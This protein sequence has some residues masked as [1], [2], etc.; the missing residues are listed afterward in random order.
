[1]KI[2]CVSTKKIE[3]AEDIK[4]CFP[5]CE[6]APNMT[7]EQKDRK[8]QEWLD[9]GGKDNFYFPCPIFTAEITVEGGK[10]DF[11]KVFAKT[12]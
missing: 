2:L 3:T 7:Q 12:A 1:M 9:A 8:I 11:E 4:K 6:I 5:I 10:E